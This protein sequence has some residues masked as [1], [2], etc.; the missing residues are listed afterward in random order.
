MLNQAMEPIKLL[1]CMTYKHDW[2]TQLLNKW[3]ANRTR[4]K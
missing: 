1:T 3:L 4:A 2:P